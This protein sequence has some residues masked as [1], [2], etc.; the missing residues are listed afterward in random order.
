MEID[1]LRGEEYKTLRSEILFH[2]DTIEKNIIACLASSAV[3]ISLAITQHYLSIFLMPIIIAM[4]F[5]DQNN[6]HRNTV[7]RI[8]TYIIVFLESET[9]TGWESRSRKILPFDKES[10]PQENE[11]LLFKSVEAHEGKLPE[12]VKKV[13]S[14]KLYQNL[15]SPYSTIIGISILGFYWELKKF[16]EIYHSWIYEA[17]FLIL[18]LIFI[19]LFVIFFSTKILKTNLPSEDL[20]IRY[21]KGFEKLKIDEIA[22]LHSKDTSNTLQTNKQ[23]KKVSSKTSK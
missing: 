16:Y 4:F 19:Y 21:R 1:D 20:E 3:I 15:V 22:E 6:Q 23:V 5:W 2:L 9:K 12:A 18:I 13:F 8:S 7:M 17:L 11:T 14:Y 10:P